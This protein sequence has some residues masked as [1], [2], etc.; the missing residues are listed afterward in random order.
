ME[1]RSSRAH[2]L[3]VGPE[4]APFEER[5]GLVRATAPS[6]RHVTGPVLLREGAN[7]L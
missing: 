3:L 4:T 7:E 2:V 1:L 5:V 6:I